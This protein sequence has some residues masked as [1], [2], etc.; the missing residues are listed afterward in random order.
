M[1]QILKE[2]SKGDDKLVIAL[3]GSQVVSHYHASL[4]DLDLDMYW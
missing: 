4:D 1:Y 3:R 2:V